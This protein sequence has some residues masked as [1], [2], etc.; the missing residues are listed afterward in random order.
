MGNIWRVAIMRVRKSINDGE[1]GDSIPN[2]EV[3]T[4]SAIAPVP[5]ENTVSH[6]PE[7]NGG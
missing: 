5:T 6:Q 3:A 1:G 4:A 2:N 7:T